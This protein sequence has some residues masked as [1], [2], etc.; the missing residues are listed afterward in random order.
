MLAEVF[1]P[2]SL[3]IFFRVHPYNRITRQA[4]KDC[5]ACEDVEVENMNRQTVRRRVRKRKSPRENSRVKFGIFL[6]IMGLA[7][8]LG[9]LTAR[10]VVGPLIGYDADESQIK[11]ISELNDADEQ[12]KQDTA[13]T[14]KSEEDTTKAEEKEKT[15][16]NATA[17][18][19]TEGYALQFGAF[20]SREAAEKLADALKEQ[21]IKVKIIETDQ[22]FKVIS[23]VVDTREE[24]L[25]SLE[26]LG[27]K[28]V[29]D[30]FI[31]CFGS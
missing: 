13:K 14:E 6:G 21:G 25:A 24:A 18:A 27:E 3:R 10:F 31:A 4:E 19:P 16:A 29:D 22:V 12:D 9:Y 7:I 26:K 8:L 2:D 1:S 20:S 15:T 23:P 17:A 30:V 11:S 5:L 28:E